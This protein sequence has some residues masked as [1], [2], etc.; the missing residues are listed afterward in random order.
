MASS[1]PS[2]SLLLFLKRIS[3]AVYLFVGA[4][5]SAAARDSGSQTAQQQHRLSQ[6]SEP[7]V[8]S[9]LLVIMFV[10]A[11]VSRSFSPRVSPV[12]PCR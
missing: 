6:A 3:P 9:L 12:I 7:L 11:I 8:S 2:S 10:S 4:V 5:V 1:P